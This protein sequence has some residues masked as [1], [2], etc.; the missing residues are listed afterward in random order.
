MGLR[1]HFQSLLAISYICVH[2]YIYIIYI[3]YI[4]SLS[5]CRHF[6]S[7]LCCTAML[8]I[9]HHFMYSNH[10]SFCLLDRPQGNGIGLVQVR[11]GLRVHFLTVLSTIR[12]IR[13]RLT[14]L[15]I[16]MVL[17]FCNESVCATFLSV[18]Y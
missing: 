8:N 6:L 5:P 10:S 7:I 13:Y 1:I 18:A 16:E 17:E 9:S 11:H 15:W 14:L 4:T 3:Y 12:H 2:T